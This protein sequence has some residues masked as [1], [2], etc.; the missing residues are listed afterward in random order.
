MGED[1]VTLTRKLLAFGRKVITIKGHDEEQLRE[2]KYLHSKTFNTVILDTFKGKGIPFLERNQ[3]YHVFYFH[4]NEEAY[5]EAV[6]YL[7]Q[8]GGIVC[9][10]VWTT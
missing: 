2:L 8:K 4:E 10:T 1:D 7:S 9:D 6:E 5:D 3:S